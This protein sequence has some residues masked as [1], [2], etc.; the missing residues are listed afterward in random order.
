MRLFRGA[1]ENESIIGAITSKWGWESNILTVLTAFR[2]KMAIVVDILVS[3]M[4]KQSYTV[5][6]ED[7]SDMFPGKQQRLADKLYR[8]ESNYKEMSREHRILTAKRS[9]VPPSDEASGPG[10]HGGGRKTVKQVKKYRYNTSKSRPNKSKPKPKTKPK[11]KSK[12]KSK[13]NLKCKRRM[14]MNTATRRRC[15]TT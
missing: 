14:N 2:Q 9:L 15:R 4:L 7:T 5:H 6:K 1:F 12:P 13:S 8:K 3:P 10:M 11:T